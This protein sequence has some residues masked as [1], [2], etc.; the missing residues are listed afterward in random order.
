MAHEVMNYHVFMKIFNTRCI[1]N[2]VKFQAK[3]MFLGHK[4]KLGLDNNY[5]DL[6]EANLL[7]E[8]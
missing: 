1:D 3:E 6:T 2:D 7:Q 4:S 8:Y 5:W